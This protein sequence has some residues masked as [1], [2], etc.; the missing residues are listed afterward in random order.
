MGKSATR[1]AC[2]A[3]IPMS[4]NSRSLKPA[5]ASAANSG[6]STSLRMLAL[7]AIS[8]MLATLRTFSFEGDSIASR[9]AVDSCA[10]PAS[11]QRNACVS[12]SKR[13]ICTRGNLPAV[14]QNPG[15]SKSARDTARS[16]EWNRKAPGRNRRSLSPTLPRCL[17][18]RVPGNPVPV[19][20]PVEPSP[21]SAIPLS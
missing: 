19:V 3:S 6:G 13:T 14:H 7:I 5:S 4:R 18:P 8:Q 12:R 20:R 17:L 2:R 10:S 1:S 15:P 21:F 11:C 16:P 9:A